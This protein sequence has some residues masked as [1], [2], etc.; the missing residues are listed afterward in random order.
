[1]CVTC[2][3]K[4]PLLNKSDPYPNL[5]A[6]KVPGGVGI[7]DDSSFVASLSPSLSVSK[8]VHQ[9]ES[10][11]CL[12]VFSSVIGSSNEVLGGFITL[13]R[14]RQVLENLSQIPQSSAGSQFVV[15]QTGFLFLT[16]VAICLSLT[17]ENLILKLLNQN[18]EISSSAREYLITLF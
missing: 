2:T 14:Q 1:M 6:V 9:P 7:D 18:Q 15:S 16:F 17:S 10:T 12:L 13:R 11:L 5:S 4:P 8:A 3:S